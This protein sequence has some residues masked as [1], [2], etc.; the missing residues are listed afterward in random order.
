MDE[1]CFR[2]LLCTAKAELGRGQPGLMR[3]I[4]DETLPQSSI[5]RSTFYSAAH[6]ATKW[7]S[8]RPYLIKTYF[9]ISLF[10]VFH[11]V[12]PRTF[13]VNPGYFT[14]SIQSLLH[15]PSKDFYRR[16]RVFY[17]VHPG[18]GYFTQLI[19]GVLQSSRVFYKVD[20]GSF[21]QSI[22]AQGPGSFTQS[23]QAQDPRSFTQS[24]RY[25]T[26]ST[27]AQG[28]LHSSYK[29]F[30][31]HPGYFTQS[32]QGLLHNPPGPGYFT[33]HPG[34][35]KQPIQ[36]LL[37]SSRVFTQSIQGLLHN[38]PRSRV[39]YSPSRAFYSHPGYSMQSIQGVLHSP[40]RVF[41]TETGFF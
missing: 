8:C 31:S 17:T 25:F 3:W 19:Q 16:S 14:Q 36:G 37:Q 9:K 35:F 41:Y 26:Q 20:P 29:V 38:P 39:F 24:S 40:S 1:R 6:R 13:T 23:T 15:N 33:V 2:P 7:A 28:I 30:Y 18:P 10:R 32:I 11:T 12:H 21:T 27:Q 34:C 22:Q 5:D 4:W